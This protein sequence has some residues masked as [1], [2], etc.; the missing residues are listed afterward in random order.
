[1]RVAED[2]AYLG[3]GRSA[4][5]HRARCTVA[6]PMGTNRRDTGTIAGAAYDLTDARPG[7][8]HD[9]GVH[10]QENGTT[11]DLGTGLGQV[12][13]ERFAHIDGQREAIDSAALPPQHELTV[14]PVKVVQLEP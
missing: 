13:D 5:Q 8:G 6:Q 12:R 4:L 10:W 9:R 11:V 2:L 14:M 3:Q 1:M 7:Q